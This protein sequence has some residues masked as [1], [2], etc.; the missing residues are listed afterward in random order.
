[1]LGMLYISKTFVRELFGLQTLEIKQQNYCETD[2]P[3]FLLK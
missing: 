1:M 3:I 2:S